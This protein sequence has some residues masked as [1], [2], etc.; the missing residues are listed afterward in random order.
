MVTNGSIDS[1]EKSTFN[2]S[3]EDNQS[4]DVFEAHNP[5]P[6]YSTYTHEY[7]NPMKTK[8]QNQYTTP[9]TFALAYKNEGFRDNSTFTSKNNSAFQSRSESI[10]DGVLNEETPII[11]S[12]LEQDDTYTASDYYNT[13]TLPLNSSLAQ[14]DATL[15]TPKNMFLEELKSK[16]PQEGYPNLPTPPEPP[17]PVVRQIYPNYNPDFNTVGVGEEAQ[18]P[19]SRSKSE[20]LLETN[21]DYE[22]EANEVFSP[23][24][25]EGSRSKSQPLETAM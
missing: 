15:D 2:S 19:K 1:I 12:S 4:Y 11:H 17:K 23:P 18:M 16:L 20:A 7:T 22:D 8:P 3:I 10:Q 21:F 6:T 13:D 5:H 25:T 9:T 14:S 24:L